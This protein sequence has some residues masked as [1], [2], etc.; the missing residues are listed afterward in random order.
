MGGAW[1]LKGRKQ[2][3]KRCKF[4]LWLGRIN[5]LCCLSEDA[6]WIPGLAQ[7]VKDPMLPRAVAQ[8]AESAQIWCCVAWQVKKTC[9]V[10]SLKKDFCHHIFTTS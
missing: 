7:R 4:P 5:N 1:D 3:Q 10:V 2:S 6:G 8:V 9:G